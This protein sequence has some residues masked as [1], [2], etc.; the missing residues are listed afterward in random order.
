MKCKGGWRDTPDPNQI[1]INVLGAADADR[2]ALELARAM[3]SEEHQQYLPITARP[4][5]RVKGEPI[6][7][8]ATPI[9]PGEP[10]GEETPLDD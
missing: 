4:Q 2:E 1:N 9:E 5:A 3:T 8:E 7:I 10:T 6:E